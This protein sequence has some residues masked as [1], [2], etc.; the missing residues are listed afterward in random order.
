MLARIAR[1]LRDDDA[2][3]NPYLRWIFT[4]AHGI[5]LPLA[6]RP[7]SFDAIRN[8]LDRLDVRRCSLEEFAR[9]HDGAAVDGWNL[10]DVFEY[11]DEAAYGALLAR[12][13][14]IVA[15][16][17]FGVLEHAVPRRRPAALAPFL[18]EREDVAAPLRAETAS[19]STATSWW[20]KRDDRR[21]RAA[22]AVLAL[23]VGG[24]ACWRCASA[25][26]PKRRARDRTSCRT[27]LPVAAAA[28]RR[29]GAGD[30]AP[31]RRLRGC[32]PC[33]P[34]RAALALRLRAARHRARVA[35]EFAFVAGVALAFV[36]AHGDFA[37]FRPRSSR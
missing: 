22:A 4:G 3:A 11:V 21:L 25:G 17:A 2:G 1:S 29:R 18:A 20:R 33:A 34:S 10:S 31:P 30:R 12:I 6:L 36:L 27:R 23:L 32:S 9:D 13:R 14:D 8:N 28:V 37:A 16:R 24:S 5:A 19:R 35:G 26:N 15:G 7:E